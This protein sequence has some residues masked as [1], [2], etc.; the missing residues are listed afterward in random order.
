LGRGEH[1]ISTLRPQGPDFVAFVVHQRHAETVGDHRHVE[2][3]VGAGIGGEQHTAF[4]LAQAFGLEL[5]AGMPAELI[6]S[7]V[8]LREDHACTLA[9]RATFPGGLNE[10]GSAWSWARR[11]TSSP[12]R[13]SPTYPGGRTSSSAS[14]GSGSCTSST[15]CRS[16]PTP[17]WS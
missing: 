5:P 12:G 15:S 7:Q 1:V 16:L 10:G 14:R 17:R 11:S 8:E 4:V 3:T 2:S 9:L 13:G 6:G